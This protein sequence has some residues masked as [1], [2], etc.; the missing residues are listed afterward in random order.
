MV[1]KGRDQRIV[2]TTGY[3]SGLSRVSAA[4]GIAEPLTLLDTAAGEL[5]YALTTAPMHGTVRASG[6]D[7]GVN[8]TFTQ[9]DI[10][11]G[12]L[13]YEHDGTETASD[14]FDFTVTDGTDTLRYR[15][16]ADAVQ[17][18]DNRKALDDATF[19]GGIKSQFG[20]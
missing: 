19:I 7:L 18:L 14:S 17:L 4:G 12:A 13:T 9:E 11:N 3:R 6:S 5:V 20:L 2:F 15:A 1:E 10:D 8:D 16:G